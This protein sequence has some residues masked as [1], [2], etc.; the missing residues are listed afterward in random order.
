VELL[1]NVSVPGPATMVSVWAYGDASANPVYIKVADATG[2]VFQGSVGALQKSWQRL[3][4]YGDGADINW[5]H[6]GGDNDGAFD[7]PLTV[8]AISVF[9]GGIGK[10]SGTAYFDDLQV[11][12]GARVR[13]LVISR[14]GGL[15][16]A[17]Y[18]LSGAPTVVVPVTGPAAWRMDGA[19][20]TP[21]TV[22][23]GTVSVGLT[24]TPINVLTTA[25][26]S[27]PAISPNGDGNA[28]SA[29]LKVVAGDRM[30]YT[31]QVLNGTGQVVRHVLVSASMDAGVR[32]VTWDGKLG[33]VA[34][35]P[36]AYTLRLA[37]IG[38][39]GRVSYLLKGVTVQ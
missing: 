29:S 36:G 39:D 32:S 16:Q 35:P 26:S 4:L 7:Y 5:S 21:L 11:E 34:A 3:V 25:G 1:R 33:G 13:G 15:N 10:L 20:S 37:V 17:L 2:E 24:S 19:T 30:L 14:R 18:S 9:R 8:K 38:P 28:D 6:S 12:T 31:F 27:P 22:S 23:A